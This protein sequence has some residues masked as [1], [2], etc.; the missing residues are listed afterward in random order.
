MAHKLNYQF[1]HFKPKKGISYKLLLGK[2]KKSLPSCVDLRAAASSVSFLPPVENQGDEGDC[3][4]HA[5]AGGLEYLQ[6]LELSMPSGGPPKTLIYGP[7]FERVSRQQL[8]WGGRAIE[9]T[10]DQDSG[11][12]DLNDMA[13]VAK[14]T[15]IARES[16][17]PYTSAD[18]FNAPPQ[19]VIDDAGQHKLT[20]SYSL[21]AGYELKHCLWS[22]FPF[23]LG[24]QVFESFISSTVA[25]TGEMPMPAQG[26]QIV[27]GH[28]VLAVGYDDARQCFI[29]RNSWGGSWGIDGYF[30]MPYEFMDSQYTGDYVTMRF[31]LTINP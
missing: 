13:T 5:T 30:H 25:A 10:T 20:A 26:E 17:W 14:L 29:I 31:D 2:Y 19:A 11:I 21:S 16:L 3:A 24:F 6:N 4:A 27:G 28:A 1:N 9:G 8:Y 7:S 12:S 15:G 18:L 23:M 22:G